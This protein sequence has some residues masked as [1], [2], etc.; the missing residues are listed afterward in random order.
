MEVLEAKLANL[1]KLNGSLNG[2]GITSFIGG[3]LRSNTKFSPRYLGKI[4]GSKNKKEDA[5]RIGRRTDRLYQ[6]VCSSNIL[7]E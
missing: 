6:Q 3:T 4:K 5:L 1:P 7:S 2:T